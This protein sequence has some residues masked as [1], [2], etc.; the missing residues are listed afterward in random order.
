[1]A[2]RVPRRGVRDQHHPAQVEPRAVGQ[3]RTRVELRVERDARQRLGVSEDRHPQRARYRG[4]AG[5]VVAVMVGQQDGVRLRSR[6]RA[7]PLDDAQERVQL[8]RV[9]AAGVDHDEA[10][11]ARH[12]DVGVGRGRERGGRDRV[13]PDP[14]RDLEPRPFRVLGVLGEQVRGQL[15]RPERSLR[16]G[17]AAEERRQRG[18]SEHRAVLPAR[19]RLARRDEAQ[20]LDLLGRGES[21]RLGAGRHDG[22]EEGAVVAQLHEGG[23]RAHADR[24]EVAGGDAHAGLLE[25]LARAAADEGAGVVR[26]VDRLDAPAGAGPVRGEEAR[27]ARAQAE[28]QLPAIGPAAHGGDDGAVDR[29]RRGGGGD[30]VGT[31]AHAVLMPRP[32]GDSRRAYAAASRPERAASA[33][34]AKAAATSAISSG[35]ASSVSCLTQIVVSQSWRVTG[36]S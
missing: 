1:M 8:G 12:P 5:D 36:R 26:A 18:G 35:P 29:R 28:Q 32:R 2:G 23:R 7:A 16:R 9:V 33:T 27:A 31:F 6:E 21:G 17:Q 22:Q 4:G 11:P 15:G 3:L 25:Q 34:F 20:L 30:A 13:E 24:V 10:R 19:D 14:V